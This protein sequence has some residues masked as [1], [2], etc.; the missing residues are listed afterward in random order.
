MNENSVVRWTAPEAN[1]Y[2]A[3]ISLRGLA[4]YMGGPPTTTGIT[5]LKATTVI[6]NTQLTA[7]ATSAV[8]D[9]SA[10]PF[11]AGEALDVRVDFGSNGN[12]MFDSTGVDVVVRAP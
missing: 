7:S 9:V 12:F 1:A 11:A 4:G 8:I 3:T 2:S 5:I 10:M 6:G